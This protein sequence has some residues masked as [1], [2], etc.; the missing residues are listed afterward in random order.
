MECKDGG[1]RRK[2]RELRVR[3]RVQIVARAKSLEN[4]VVG[5]S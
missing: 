4:I 3:Y 2:G 5:G 1:M